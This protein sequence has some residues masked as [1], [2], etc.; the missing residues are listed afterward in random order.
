[1]FLIFFFL[2]VFNMQILLYIFMDHLCLIVALPMILQP[3][4][5]LLLQ[6]LLV[7]QIFHIL[8]IEL[9]IHVLN[10]LKC[11]LS[12]IYY[13][14]LTLLRATQYRFL[15]RFLILFRIQLLVW[16]TRLL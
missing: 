15:I 5:R 9:L 10:V 12:H 14:N 13:S 8:Q 3:S 2:L 1:M 4:L 16:D 11:G 7:L 6:N